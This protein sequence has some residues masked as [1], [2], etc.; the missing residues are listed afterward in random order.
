M[1]AYIGTAH[2]FLDKRFGGLGDG[3]EEQCKWR[4]GFAEIEQARDEEKV[5]GSPV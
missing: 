1:G 5:M 3:V 2:E 4:G